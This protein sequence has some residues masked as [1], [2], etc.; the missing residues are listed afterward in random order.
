MARTVAGLPK[1][2]RISDHVTL[3]VLTTTVPASLIDAVLVD[4]G[5]QSV[6]QRLLPARLVVYYVMA[7]A[8]YG[9]A[10]YGEVLRCLLEGVRWLHRGGTSLVFATKSSITKARRRLGPAPLAELYRRVA[11]PLAEPGLPGC[12]FR[13]RRL[14][15]LDGTTIDLPDAPDLVTRFGRP[16]ASRGESAFPQ[17]RLMA[18]AETGTHAVFAA[19]S[20]TC[21]PACCAWPTAPSSASSCGRRRGP[22]VPTCC[23]ACASTK[24]CPATRSC[25]MART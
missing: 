25:P 23:G 15:S 18:L 3:G 12:F 7:L 9:Q 11:R 22:P 1:G 16:A 5:C 17:L 2:T 8:L 10:A 4:T 13:G 14:V 6:R 19:C 24:S 21:G 20:T